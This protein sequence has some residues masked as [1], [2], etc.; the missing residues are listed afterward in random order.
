[1]KIAFLFL[2]YDE[3]VH[4]DL[5]AKFFEGVDPSLYMIYIHYKNDKKLK[6][7]EK[8]KL[9]NCVETEFADISLISCSIADSDFA[10]FSSANLGFVSWSVARS[11]AAKFRIASWRL[12]GLGFASF[13]FA[14]FFIH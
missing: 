6:H 13:G 8:Y 11:S 9:K 5:W 7:F 4:E 1:M 12:A 10:C 2:I 14:S 3:I